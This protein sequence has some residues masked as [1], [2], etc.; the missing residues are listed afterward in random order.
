[1]SNLFY[2]PLGDW[3]ETH[4]RSI[5]TYYTYSD[6]SKT[7][8]TG[9]LDIGATTGVPQYAMCDGTITYCGQK[10]SGGNTYCILEC[11][12]DQNNLGE[13]FYIR[14]LHGNYTV[15]TGDTV[16]KGQKIGTT[17]AI[18]NAT[19]P[20]LHIGF[21]G[22]S[23]GSRDPAISGSVIEKDGTKYFVR[24][25]KQYPLLDNIDW[26][27]IE[28]WKA[29]LGLT[30]NSDIGYCWL[31]MAS[32]F[33]KVE[34]STS[35]S[36]LDASQYMNNTVIGIDTT[37]GAYSISM[38]DLVHGVV[39]L[40]MGAY[41]SDLDNKLN[42]SVVEWVCR[43]A[44]NRL[45]ASNGDGSSIATWI[46]G[47]SDQG[48]YMSTFSPYLPDKAV[49]FCDNIIGGQ[50]YF[51]AEKMA[52][53]YR[54]GNWEDARFYD[55]LYSA[56]TFYAGTVSSSVLATIPMSGGTV[57]FNSLLNNDGVKFFYPDGTSNKSAYP[58]PYYKGGVY[59]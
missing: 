32:K 44:R 2:H 40:E 39:Q 4:S 25:G 58:N 53:I 6:A 20:H 48:K 59:N 38:K 45:V 17:A 35:S 21:S 24:N 1:M 56:E 8:V 26:D 43:C 31:V 37:Y 33:E 10:Q 42:A 49:T 14:Y 5:N 46:T 15:S 12:A 27:L 11:G 13:T 34:Q 57:Y 55:H 36:V 23:D 50:D 30:D 9:E 41:T 28:K 22:K 16:K 3:V 18:G 7:H 29:Q 51:Y 54:Y 19:G 47:N 52:E